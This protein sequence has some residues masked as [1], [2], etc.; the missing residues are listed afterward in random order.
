MLLRTRNAPGERRSVR[1]RNDA[2]RPRLIDGRVLGGSWRVWQRSPAS[3]R[4]SD[5]VVEGR[6]SSPGPRPRRVLIVVENLPVPF[7][8]RVWNEARTLAADGWQVSVI[9]PMGKGWTRGHEVIDDVAIYRH[10]LPQGTGKLAYVAEY[11]TALACQFALACWIYARRGFDVIHGC[12]PPDTIFLV[13]GVFKLLFGIRYVFD[14][15]DSSPEFFVAKFDRAG[16]LHRLL[17]LLERWSFATADVVIATNDSHRRIALQRGRVPE[18]RV[19]VV[20]SGPTTERMRILPPTP[21]LKNGRRHLVAYLGLI[22]EQEG[23]DLLLQAVRH[24]V[25]DH[26]REDVQFGVVGGGPALDEMRALRDAMRLGDYVTFTGRASDADLLAMLNTADLCVNPDRVNGYTTICTMNKVLEYMALAKPVVQFDTI[27]GRVSA[28]PAAVYASPN[29]PADLAARI[30]DLLDDPERRR[31]M[32]RI[33]YERV[34]SELSWEHQA[35]HLLA[36]YR[37]ALPESVAT[38]P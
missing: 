25:D 8:T 32:G 24:I 6:D 10:P 4:R 18:R 30:L 29:D 19:F 26:R 3:G 11:A 16:T 28:G 37:A 36:A 23:I 1:R 31:A 14:H 22:S 20:R 9:C 12:S 27:E 2:S 13:A 35:A 33:G 5:D 21:A 38:P 7:D 34:R 15:H 17:L